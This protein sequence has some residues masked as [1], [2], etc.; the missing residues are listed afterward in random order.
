MTQ[1]GKDVLMIAD[2]TR[3]RLT[4]Q[5]PRTVSGVCVDSLSTNRLASFGEVKH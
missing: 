1:N 3:P 2:T 5:Q 4:T